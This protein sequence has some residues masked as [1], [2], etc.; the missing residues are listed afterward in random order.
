[1][2]KREENSDEQF[3]TVYKYFTKIFIFTK[4][5]VKILFL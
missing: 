2:Y 4:F 5:L 1:M 3:I